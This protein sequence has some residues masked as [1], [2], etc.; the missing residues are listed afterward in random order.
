MSEKQNIYILI[1]GKAEVL[2]SEKQFINV[3]TVII[4]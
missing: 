2:S 3:N 4:S 1:H